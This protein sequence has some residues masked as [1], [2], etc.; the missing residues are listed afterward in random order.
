MG[1]K[2]EAISCADLHPSAFKNCRHYKFQ[3]NGEI[4]R[5]LA[6]IILTAVVSC[7]IYITR[8]DGDP[9]QSIRSKSLTNVHDVCLCVHV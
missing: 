3:I 8:I 9:I 5:D 7:F 1:E 4:P 2:A 6:I